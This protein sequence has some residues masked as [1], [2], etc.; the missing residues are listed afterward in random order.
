MI[1]KVGV[2]ARG[3]AMSGASRQRQLRKRRRAG[4]AIFQ[5]EANAFE[6]ADALVVAGWLEQW[7]ADDRAAIEA[8][9]VRAIR[10]LVAGE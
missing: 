7:D 1:L 5:I 8:A 4:L 3:Q 2:D 6:L 10:H 9:L